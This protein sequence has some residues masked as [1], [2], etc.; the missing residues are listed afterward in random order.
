[1]AGTQQGLNKWKFHIR[2]L[3]S[4]RI[5]L[6]EEILHIS[7][8]SDH[9]V[10]YRDSGPFLNP[11]PLT[12]LLFSFAQISFLLHLPDLFWLERKDQKSNIK[13]KPHLC[14][15]ELV[16]HPGKAPLTFSINNDLLYSF[17]ANLLF[18]YPPFI[19]D[20]T[21]QLLKKKSHFHF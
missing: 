3:R 16:F 13:D 6:L 9:R 19:T 8:S 17:K 1:M 4:T 7:G 15:N 10:T 14:L 18:N 21:L 11:T 20:F 2:D 12:L 5:K